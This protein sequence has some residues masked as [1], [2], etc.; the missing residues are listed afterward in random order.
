MTAFPPITEILPHRGIMLFIDAVSHFSPEAAIC[1]F[2]P[3]RNAWYINRE[4]AMPAWFGIE[5]MAQSIAV[6]AALTAKSRGEQ[7]KFGA[8]LGSRDY[9]CTQP[10][11][12]AGAPLTITALQELRDDS[13]LGAYEC[14]IEAEGQ[15][16]SRAQLKVFEPESFEQFLA[17]GKPA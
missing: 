5:M 12:I 11:Y 15:I 14:R 7:P 10:S 2:Q 1:T 6:H 9:H 13:G 17:T 3:Q 8:L 16:I 4:G